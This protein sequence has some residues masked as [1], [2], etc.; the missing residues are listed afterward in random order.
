M[1][2]LISLPTTTKLLNNIV[3]ANDYLVEGTLIGPAYFV[4]VDQWGL[5]TLIATPL[6][7]FL[8]NSGRPNCILEQSKDIWNIWTVQDI[9]IHE[10]ISINYL[11]YNLL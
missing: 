1:Q 4:Y 9:A 2:K 8:Q 6:G 7:G 11:I 5:K 3:V 10:E